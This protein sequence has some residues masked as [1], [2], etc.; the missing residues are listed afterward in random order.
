MAGDLKTKYGTSNQTITL[1]MSAMPNSGA[2]SCAGID[3]TT[4]LFI[5]ALVQIN[6]KTDTT[7]VSAV[8][9]MNVYAVGTA[10]GGT[11]YAEGGTHAAVTMTNPPNARLI[12][13]INTVANNTAYK[14]GPFSV[15]N[16]FGG[17]LPDHWAIIVENRTGAQ[18]MATTTVHSIFYQ[19][20]YGQIGRAH[21]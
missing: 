10:D 14:G 11:T 21:V 15:A 4:N 12:G 6:T 5:D 8:G 9:V 20:V 17:V 18:L 3:N 1:S 13:V 2:V 19:G 7:G 16:A